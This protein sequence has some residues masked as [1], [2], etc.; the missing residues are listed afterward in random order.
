M[1]YY[2]TIYNKI[3]NIKD[4]YVIASN[5]QINN[6]EYF[7]RVYYTIDG[8]GTYI[9]EPIK[10]GNKVTERI[11]ILGQ[12]KGYG[13][14]FNSPFQIGRR[15]NCVYLFN[16]CTN[17]NQPIVIPNGVTNCF[18]MFWN[19]H[20]LVGPVTIGTGSISMSGMFYNCLRYPGDPIT[21]PKETINTSSMFER[22]SNFNAPVTFADNSN[23]IDCGSMFSYCSNFNQNIIIP[24]GVINCTNLLHRCYNFTGTVVIPET[25]Y[26]CYDLCQETK[27]T[28]LYLKINP[29]G[30]YYGFINIGRDTG[31]APRLNIFT[32][33]SYAFTAYIY[34]TKGM[35]WSSMTE[36][37]QTVFYNAANNI[38]IYNNYT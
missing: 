32:N 31:S 3:Y 38:Y 35:G 4:Y 37:G 23:L 27:V 2:G 21:I 24:N 15:T 14:S 10:I 16:N 36:E 5:G 8:R 28:N 20:N 18:R 33:N 19:C 25:A 11:N 34:P 12:E 30:N 22:C 26:M 13:Y 9:D 1:S 7:N 17:F 29:S 6:D